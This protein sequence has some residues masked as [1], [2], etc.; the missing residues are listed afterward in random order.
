MRV[1]FKKEAVQGG[2]RTENMENL[3]QEAKVIRKQ[4]INPD[5]KN[6]KKG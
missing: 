3:K 4:K 2:V 6:E 1:Q 5:I